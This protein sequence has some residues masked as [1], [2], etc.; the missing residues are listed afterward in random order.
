[1]AGATIDHLVS[2]TIFLAALLLFISFFN[3]TIQTAMLYQQHSATA[4]KCSD[5]LD[6]MLLNPANGMPTFFGL[7]KSNSPQYTLD[8]SS[9]MWLNSSTGTP[10][11]YARN[12]MMY[13]N[14]TVGFGNSL[15]VNMSNVVAY[16][17]AL[18]KLGIKDAYGSQLE[19]SPVVNVSIAEVQSNPLKLSVN[20]SGVG[21]PLAYAAVNYRL[22]AISLAGD[23]PEYLTIPNQAGTVYTDAA[24]NVSILFQNFASNATRTYAF[25]AHSHVGG[26]TGVGF[27]A[28]DFS[29]NPRVIPLVG[30]PNG[31]VLLAHSAD[32][33]NT[34]SSE[35]LNYTT[36]FVKFSNDNFELQ[37]NATGKVKSGA[38]PPVNIVVQD[39]A[40]ILVIAYR[41]TSSGGI[42]VMP[43]GVGSLAFP[44]TFGGD[45]T[46][47]E[48][49]ATDMRQVLVNGVAYQAKLSLWSLTGVQ[50]VG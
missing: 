44:V 30:S 35:E 23:Y 31:A 38:G 27:Y 25:V 46:E 49:V 19:L 15:L 10:V 13:S 20:V 47:Q 1:M 5:L 42:A 50:V 28:P 21:F 18:E 6:S 29:A 8:P 24:G 36:A 34:T 43:W 33:L 40:G 41:A 45:P 26:L 7:R 11:Y 17:W 39:D 16:S 14:I 22:I 48:W 2:V 37:E 3:Q 4:T 12:G 9:L 32:V